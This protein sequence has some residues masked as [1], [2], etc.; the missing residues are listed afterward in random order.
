VVEVPAH[1]FHPYSQP[2]AAGR[3]EQMTQRVQVY[4]WAKWGETPHM[5]TLYRIDVIACKV[6]S[7][8]LS[9]NPLKSVLLL[10]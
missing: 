2:G 8:K 7:R 5:L 9:V 1:L 3:L 6:S 4:C 10:E